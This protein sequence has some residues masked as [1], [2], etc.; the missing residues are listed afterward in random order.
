MFKQKR[1]SI[2]LDQKILIINEVNSG[3]KKSDILLKYNFTNYTNLN[4]IK[5]NEKKYI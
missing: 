4:A 1:K 5:K 3:T 2:T